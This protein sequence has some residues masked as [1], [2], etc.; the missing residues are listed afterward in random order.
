MIPWTLIFTLANE[1]APEIIPEVKR[2]YAQWKEKGIEPTQAQWDGLL[3]RIAD[4][5][6]LKLLAA[7]AAKAAA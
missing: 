4:N 2:L 6:F 5:S 3:G 7:E 1:A